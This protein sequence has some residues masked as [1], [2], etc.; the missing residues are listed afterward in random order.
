MKLVY[1]LLGLLVLVFAGGFAWL[2]VSDAA[3]AQKEIVRTI[4]QDRYAP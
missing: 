4:P 3:P 1:V 2:I